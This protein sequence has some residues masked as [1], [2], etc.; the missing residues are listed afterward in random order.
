MRGGKVV[1]YMNMFIYR[2]RRP[3]PLDRG[4]PLVPEAW[5]GS[6]L[7]PALAWGAGTV[8]AT[9]TGGVL[10][11]RPGR[12]RGF[13]RILAGRRSGRPLLTGGRR[14]P[15]RPLQTVLSGSAITTRVG[16]SVGMAAALMDRGGH[17]AA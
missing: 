8:I 16:A 4:A 12:L 3:L 13:L 9:A 7:K 1:L 17:G 14:R 2:N 10:G 5:N 6:L 11:G 15:V